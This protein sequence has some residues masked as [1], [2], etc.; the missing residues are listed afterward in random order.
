MALRRKLHAPE[1]HTTDTQ[2]RNFKDIFDSLQTR[3][4][5]LQLPQDLS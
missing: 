3:S 4:S 2:P 5:S 1:L